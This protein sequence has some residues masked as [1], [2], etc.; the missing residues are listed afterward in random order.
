ETVCTLTELNRKVHEVFPDVVLIGAD[1]LRS[2]P[3]LVHSRALT[4]LPVVVMAEAEQLAGQLQEVL[5]VAA[6]AEFVVIPHYKLFPQFRNLQDEIIRKIKQVINSRQAFQQLH[7][8]FTAG[9]AAPKKPVS[10]VVIGAS[11]GGTAAIEQIVKNLCTRLNAAVLIAVHLPAKFT[12]TFAKRLASLTKL[13]V[14]E[15]QPGTR[16]EAGKIIIAPGGQNMLVVNQMGS[17]TNLAVALTDETDATYDMPSVD[18]LM[19]SA[20]KHAKSRTL[21]VILTGLGTD[22]TAGAKAVLKKGGT[23]IAQDKKSSA[24]FGMA[25]SAIKQGAV[26][27]VMP[28]TKIAE[29]INSF[30]AKASSSNTQEVHSSLDEI[31]R[32]GV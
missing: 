4:D 5:T 10:V 12:K 29:Y 7:R 31:E 24:I 25:S 23:V 20:V 9:L 26:T 27:D 2:H 32:A 14:V 28:L 30:A 3:E 11:T 21:G 16:L 1:F 15:G 17:S 6:Q 13:K 8:Q 18:F 22:G 19:K